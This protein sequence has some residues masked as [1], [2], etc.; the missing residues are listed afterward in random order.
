MSLGPQAGTQGS[1]AGSSPPSWREGWALA[2]AL[3]DWMVGPQAWLHMIKGPG[4][5]K[6]RVMR[7]PG[8]QL[9]LWTV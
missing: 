2:G 9:S 7:P 1:L 6:R 3:V 8:C 4:L 5:P